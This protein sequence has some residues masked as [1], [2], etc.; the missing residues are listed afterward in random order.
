MRFI[1]RLNTCACVGAC[2]CDGMPL[3]KGP[4]FYINFQIFCPF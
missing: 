4:D 2:A 3:L 1:T